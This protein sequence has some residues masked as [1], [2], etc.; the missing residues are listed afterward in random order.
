R[1]RERWGNDVFHE[2]GEVDR[3]R[4]GAIVFADPK[5][6]RA[7]EKLS[8]PWIERRF[9][10]EAEKANHDPSVRFVVLDAAVMLEAG[11]NKVCDRLVYID[12]PR[13]LRLRRLA[14]H[15]GWMPEDVELR[16]RAQWPLEE[17][18]KRADLVIENA[19]SREQ[20][21]EQVEGLVRNLEQGTG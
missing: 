1:I 11:W 2:Q 16:E 13:E 18:R 9:Q 12:A 10:E 3:R 20:L 7:L 8:F 15:R 14:Q 19:G 21:T 17:K 6:L 5:E 4:L